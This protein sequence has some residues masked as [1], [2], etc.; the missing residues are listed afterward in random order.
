[1]GAGAGAGTIDFFNRGC[2]YDPDKF[3]AGLCFCWFQLLYLCLFMAIIIPLYSY[4]VIY[5]I[6]Q[7]I[8]PMLTE[9]IFPTSSF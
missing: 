8:I 7:V 1:M 3:L 6:V 4:I 9:M 5:I 2:G